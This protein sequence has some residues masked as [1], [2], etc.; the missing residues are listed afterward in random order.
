[1]LYNFLGRRRT[2]GPAQHREMVTL[3]RSDGSVFSPLPEWPAPSQIRLSSDILTYIREPHDQVI[4]VDFFP[5]HPHVNADGESLQHNQITKT[6]SFGGFHSGE[7]DDTYE[8]AVGSRYQI[9]ASAE[10]PGVHD[11]H[12]ALPVHSSAIKRQTYGRTTPPQ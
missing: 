5:N 4:G 9:G 6:A 11:R 1:M 10:V 7:A 2:A 12:L 8:R 3:P